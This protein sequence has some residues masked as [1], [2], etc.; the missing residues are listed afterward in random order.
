MTQG[1]LR[2]RKK[3]SAELTVTFKP[4]KCSFNGVN[5]GIPSPAEDEEELE[6][7]S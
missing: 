2:E 1:E 5:A 7:E 6:L 3:S 4:S